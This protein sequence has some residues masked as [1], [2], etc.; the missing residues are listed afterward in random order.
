MICDAYSNYSKA[1]HLPGRRTASSLIEHLLLWQLDNGFARV[2]QTDGAKV[3]IGDEFQNFL[4]ENKIEHRLSAPMKS[5]SNGRVEERIKAYKNMLT[6]LHYEGRKSEGETRA[7]WELLNNMPSR[8]GEFSP[9]RLAFPRERRHPLMPCL[10]A[11][12]GEIEKG[13]QQLQDKADEQVRRNSKKG[14]HIKKPDKF[15][16]GQRVLT[17]K[18]SSGNAKSDK[19]FTVPAKVLAIRPNTHER[20]AIL[21]LPDGRTTIR[22]RINCC[23]DPSQPQPD[24]IDNIK[25]C[26][27]SYLKLISKPQVSK[28]DEKQTIASM[29]QKIKAQGEKVRLMADTGDSIL[30]EVIPQFQQHS[31]MKKSSSHTPKHVRFTFQEREE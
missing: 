19:S 20:S 30:V 17:Q 29:L 18:Y 12:G 24:N 2:L 28:R 22:D 26:G 10:P 14:K 9:A 3:F 16:V 13:R 21:E 4:Q 27:T 6:K 8:P 25:E 5:S 7:T 11:E 31:C 1:I 15:V 23:I